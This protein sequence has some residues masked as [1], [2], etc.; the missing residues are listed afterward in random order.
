MKYKKGDCVRGTAPK[1]EGIVVS[2]DTTDKDFVFVRWLHRYDEHTQ[3]V[4]HWT[5]FVHQE[6]LELIPLEEIT[7]GIHLLHRE[8]LR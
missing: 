7:P 6:D 5:E 4:I 1:Q 3:E 8:F 2:D